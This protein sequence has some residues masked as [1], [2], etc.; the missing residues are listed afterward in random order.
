MQRSDGIID[1][2]KTKYFYGSGL[3]GNGRDD[4]LQA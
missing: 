3:Y 1:G 4:S 2:L